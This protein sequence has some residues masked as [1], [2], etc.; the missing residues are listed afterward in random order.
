MKLQEL[1]RHGMSSDD[2]AIFLEIGA[3]VVLIL[4]LAIVLLVRFAGAA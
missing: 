1:K 4:V 3:I 2:R